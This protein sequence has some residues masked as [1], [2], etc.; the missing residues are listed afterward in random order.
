MR[1]ILIPLFADRVPAGFPSPASD[2]I[3]TT[4]DPTSLLIRRPAA[5]YFVRA[6]GT[7]MIRI[8]ILDGSVLVV[9]R[10]LTPSPGD[11]VIAVVDGELT[12]KRLLQRG[13][14]GVLAPANP[15]FPEIP[16]DQD[17]GVQTCGVVTWTLTQ[18]CNR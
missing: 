4:L 9:D 6:A 5:T 7:S 16:I 10:S 1:K 11:V 14:R 8:G 18:L 17:L 15:E 12:V 13:R 2:F 3:E